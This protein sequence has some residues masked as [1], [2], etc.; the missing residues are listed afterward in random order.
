L[1]S[2]AVHHLIHSSFSASFMIS[3]SS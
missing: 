1:A 2:F 3:R